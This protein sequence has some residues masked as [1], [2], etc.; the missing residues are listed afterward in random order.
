VVSA[1]V[2]TQS[3]AANVSKTVRVEHGRP[4]IVASHNA[5]L[6]L[7]FGKEP[8]KAA[9]SGHKDPA[10]RYCR[11][12]YRYR[13]FEGSS[14]AI[15]SGEGTVEEIY[16]VIKQSASGSEVAD[17]GSRTGINTG[18]FNLNWSQG[19][20]GAR[21]WIYYRTDSGIRFLQQP[22]NVKFE[23]IDTAQFRQ[24]MESRNVQEFVAAG[25]R[26]QVIG[27]A[28]FSGDLPEE[29]S[30]SARIESATIKQGV[31]ELKLTDLVARKPYLIESSYTTEP[32]N[33]N[34]VHKFTAGES[35]LTWSDPLSSDVNMV[36]YRIREG[37]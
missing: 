1:S 33:W 20:A 21:S 29:T 14:G 2:L 27:P 31:F 18:E 24:Y 11:A 26:V 8:A 23:E 15:S 6:L 10:L 9:L 22:Q 28:V 7:E 16:E 13:L 30:V 37:H 25:Q 34:V 36:F 19:T 5:V 35:T 12:T 3:F 32:G 4:V 17:R